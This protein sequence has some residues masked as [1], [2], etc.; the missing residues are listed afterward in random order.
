MEHITTPD[1]NYDA[2]K[3]IHDLA[4]W[5]D[6]KFELPGGLRIG[7]DGLIGLIPGIG[8]TVGTFLSFY[9]V[10]EAARMGASIATLVRMIGNILLELFVGAIPI[11]GD[12]FDFMWKANQRNIALLNRQLDMRPA[13]GTAESR[14]AT[15]ASVVFG[16]GLF[17]AILLIIGVVQLSLKILNIIFD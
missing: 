10:A 2:H 8:D 13:H 12:L 15:S 17:I 1:Y 16:I 6:D 3:R 7:F 4:R 5:L 14:M 11:I 9:I